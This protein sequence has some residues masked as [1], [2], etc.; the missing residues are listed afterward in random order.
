MF[1]LCIK[2]W[3]SRAS[4]TDF[5]SCMQFVL[6]GSPPCTAYSRANTTGQRDLEVADELVAV[7][8]L[9]LETLECVVCVMEN[10]ATGLLPGREVRHGV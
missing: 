1:F 7:V 3:E 8:Q 10:P 4:K 9:L 2:F 5:D 6:L